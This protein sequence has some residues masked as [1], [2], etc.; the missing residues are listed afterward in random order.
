MHIFPWFGSL[1]L[2]TKLDFWQIKKHFLH[3]QCLE[4]DKTYNRCMYCRDVF[5]VFFF[6]PIHFKVWVGIGTMALHQSIA[7]IGGLDCDPAL[8]PALDPTSHLADLRSDWL[9]GDLRGLSSLCQ[10]LHLRSGNRKLT[11][12]C[13]TY[14]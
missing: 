4:R 3:L 10:L 12:P 1:K 5:N 9:M 13:I 11:E 2:Q 6:I 8:P 7:A 14:Y